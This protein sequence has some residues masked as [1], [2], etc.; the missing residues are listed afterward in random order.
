MDTKELVEIINLLEDTQN[1]VSQYLAFEKLGMYE[2]KDEVLINRL[3]G[4]PYD[5]NMI[6]INVYNVEEI[7][8]INSWISECGEDNFSCTPFADRSFLRNFLKSVPQEKQLKYIINTNMYYG[9]RKAFADKRYVMVTRRSIP[10]IEDKPEAFWSEEAAT[11]LWGLKYEI[12]KEQRAYSSILVS[13]LGMLE[14]HGAVDFEL[15]SG[16]VSDGEIVVS[17]KPF[18]REK[19]L[20]AFKQ[21]E[22]IFN[23]V[24]T[25]KKSNTSYA[26]FVTELMSTMSSRYN[27]TVNENINPEENCDDF[28]F[29]DWD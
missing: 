4:A 29:G 24:E 23:L 16:G 14:E 27:R 13:T 15:L 11:P 6:P 17:G 10:T 20:F 19:I 9:Q 18:P 7:S 28:E 1:N 3:T 26:E 2:D 22:E 25:V 5:S 21:K 8:L 12:S